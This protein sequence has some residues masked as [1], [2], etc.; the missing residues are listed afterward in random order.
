MKRSS[1]TE[2]KPQ[3]VCSYL[4]SR[5]KGFMGDFS[6]APKRCISTVCS[7]GLLK[8]LAENCCQPSLR[9]TAWVLKGWHSGQE[10]LFFWSQAFWVSTKDHPVCTSL[11]Q[12][13]IRILSEFWKEH[14]RECQ[15]GKWRK[16]RNKRVQWRN[17]CQGPNKSRWNRGRKWSW[18]RYFGRS[19][20]K[21]KNWA[22]L[23]ED[24]G[25]QETIREVSGF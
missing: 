4:D 20:R 1:R 12:G 24:N 18:G 3:P 8:R 14:P 11:E 13:P 19:I 21:K 6:A 10:S 9:C 7:P 17:D 22:Q 16:E 2:W 25:G 5:E 23:N 15:G